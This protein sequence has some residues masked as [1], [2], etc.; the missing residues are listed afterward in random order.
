MRLSILNPAV[1]ELLHEAAKREEIPFTIAASARATGTDADVIHLSRAGVPTGEVSIALRYMHSP[2]EMVQLDDI[3]H[4]ARL[5][6]AF[7]Q[8]LSTETSFAR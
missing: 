6:A 7:A 8:A 1:F 4:C 3:D 5:I 2:V